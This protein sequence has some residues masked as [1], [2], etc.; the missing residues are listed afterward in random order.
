[1]LLYRCFLAKILNETDSARCAGWLA[2]CRCRARACGLVSTPPTAKIEQRAQRLKADEHHNHPYTSEL[3]P[4][5]S[6]PFTRAE[7]IRLRE[8]I[9]SW[10]ARGARRRADREVEASTCSISEIFDNFVCMFHSLLENPIILEAYSGSLPEN[11]GQSYEYRA[12]AHRRSPRSL[13][14]LG[15]TRIAYDR[16]HSS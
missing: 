12:G 6:L 1:M 4:V 5:L 10:G 15:R 3:L 16:Y 14:C 7:L 13:H 9:D 11:R 8:V 2:R